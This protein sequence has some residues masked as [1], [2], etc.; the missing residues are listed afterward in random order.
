MN[1]IPYECG[2]GT[3]ETTNSSDVTP[4]STP[5]HKSLAIRR[6]AEERFYLPEAT[7]RDRVLLTIAVFVKGGLMG[8]YVPFFTLWLFMH[9]YSVQQLGLLIAVDTISS[10]IFMPM[11]GIVLD[12]G[13]CHNSGLVV[14][15]FFLGVLKLMTVMIADSFWFILCTTA[16][17]SPMLK[18][19]NSVL[20][21]QCLFAFKD[22]TMFPKIRVW[23]SIGFGVLAFF[24]GMLV[25]YVGHGGI[26]YVFY[27]FAALTFGTAIYWHIAH[28]Y[29]K[30][31]PPDGTPMSLTEHHGMLRRAYK[32]VNVH[33]ILILLC[34]FACGAL[35]GVVGSFEF[36]LLKKLN[37]H[38]YWMGACRLIG[39]I[40]ELPFWWY[41]G[42]LLD[43]FAVLQILTFCLLGNAIRL[44]LYGFLRNPY[45][46][47][48]PEM[49]HGCTF[50]LPYAA[51][52]IYV[53]RTVQEENRAMIQ[54]IVLTF[55]LGLGAG[56]GASV[57]GY[58][59]E[60][61]S[62]HTMFMGAGFV[63]IAIAS[64][65]ITYHL[66]YQHIPQAAFSPS[67]AKGYAKKEKR[68]LPLLG[69]PMLNYLYGDGINDKG[70][71]AEGG[72]CLSSDASSTTNPLDPGADPSTS[73]G[74][75][76]N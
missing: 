58:F 28:K 27:F 73:S 57:G 52:S 66:I 7:T 25:H 8:A 11:I 65:I 39:V 72:G 74:S 18:G 50:A 51:I 13:R 76:Q 34:L 75:K 22:K 29:I 10:T 46:A 35:L 24:S 48:I 69:P 2:G 59:A 37:A 47:V 3:G 41:S 43:H 62:I 26:D 33:S 21:A 23:G 49:L 45:W 68:Q 54:S 42:N 17:S 40:L 5:P 60:I 9:G 15:L 56:A 31:I 44:F 55:F 38:V 67:A 12:K 20:D 64:F 61:Y 32:F 14:I 1:K 70:G 36:I 16:L 30:I 71:A 63:G 53:G 4:S 6:D 19:A